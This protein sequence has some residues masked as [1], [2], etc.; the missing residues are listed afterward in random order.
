MKLTVDPC[1]RWD[2]S[3]RHT[4]LWSLDVILDVGLDDSLAALIEIVLLPLIQR[5]HLISH[6]WLW[7]L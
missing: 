1:M 5:L 4:S 6:M 2:L 3:L 7:P